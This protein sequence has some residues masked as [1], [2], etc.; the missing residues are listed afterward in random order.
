MQKAHQYR[1]AE[2]ACAEWRKKRD[3][4]ARATRGTSVAESGEADDGVGWVDAL[5]GRTV[6][7]MVGAVAAEMMI[8]VVE[9]MRMIRV[10]K[11]AS[12]THLGH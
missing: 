12:E 7:D 8:E 3:E 9:V 11:I 4:N 5:R 1:G 10:S 6:A 2:R